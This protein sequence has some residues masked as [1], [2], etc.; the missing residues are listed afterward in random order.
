MTSSGPSGNY[1]PT[2]P[3]KL[4]ES[5]LKASPDVDR[6]GLLKFRWMRVLQIVLDAL[7]ASISFCGAFMI[8][9]DGRL[10]EPTQGLT[11]VHQLIW[12]FASRC[13][14][15]TLCE[16]DLRC[17]P[18]I[19]ALY[20]FDRSH[21]TG[22][23][24]F[25]GQHHLYI[26]RVLNLLAVDNNQLS[27]GIISIDFGLCFIILTGTPRFADDCRQ[28]HNQRRHWRQPVRRRALLV[29]AGDAGQMVLRELAQR[30]DLGVD[31]VGLLDDDPQKVKKRMGKS[32]HIRYHSRV[33]ETG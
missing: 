22:S 27:F 7:L 23:F 16:L 21:G 28:K 5:A 2:D 24:S 6:H 14:S 20:R 12:L 30:S 13:R 15:E 10:V 26:A 4:L 32:H 31:V 18:K 33:A 17:L 3:T 25:V 8:R 29:G 19:V 9:F 11:Y 1:P